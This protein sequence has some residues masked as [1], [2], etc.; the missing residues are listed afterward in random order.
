MCEPTTIATI[1]AISAIGSSALSVMSANKQAAATEE[2]AKNAA[3]ADYVQQTEQQDQVNQQASLD[4]AQRAKQAMMDRA[5]LRVAQGESG[6][7]GIS[8]AKEM[9]AVDFNE[10]YDM[11]VIESNRMN[12]IRQTEAEKNATRA[13]AQGRINMAASQRTPGWAAGLQI[14]M[15]GATGAMQGY[16]MG[17]SWELE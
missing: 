1:A 7:S 13:N 17:K 2:A 10:Y 5:S 8:S 9:G 3:A 4:Q 15:A 16:T 14:G 6:L 11:S 12:R